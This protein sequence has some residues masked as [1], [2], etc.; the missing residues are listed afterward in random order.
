MAYKVYRM[1]RKE[2]SEWNIFHVETNTTLALR[3]G[4]DG[5]PTGETAESALKALETGKLD[6]LKGTTPDNA[7]NF[8]IILEDGTLSN[9][10][11]NVHTFAPV[12]HT[13]KNGDI[14]TGVPSV[15]AVTDAEGKLSTANDISVTILNY[16]SGLHENVQNRLD[17]V[18]SIRFDATQ[19]TDQPENG[20]WFETLA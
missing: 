3:M 6:K 7:L 18:V 13:H 12:E 17:Q 5:N 15:V 11:T 1:R 14:T 4:E 8:P 16:L 9:S 10:G 20:L 19:P 2:G